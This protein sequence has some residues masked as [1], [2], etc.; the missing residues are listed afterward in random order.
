MTSKH[1][2]IKGYDCII[3][4]IR[5]YVLNANHDSHITKYG[6][7]LKYKDHTLIG[8]YSTSMGPGMASSVVCATKKELLDTIK[9]EENMIVSDCSRIDKTN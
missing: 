5:Y 8:G 6:W 3:E 2:T 7:E 1:I 9:E 4:R